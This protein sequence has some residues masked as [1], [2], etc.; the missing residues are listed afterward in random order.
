MTQASERYVLSA[1]GGLIDLDFVS[2]ALGGTYWAQERPRAVIEASLRNSLCFGAYEKEGGRQ[3]AFARIVTD[4]ATFSWLCDVVV[5]PAHRGHGLGKR[6]VAA[7]VA[8]PRVAGTFFLLATRDAH[9]LY[10]RFGFERIEMMKRQ[11]EPAAPPRSAS[12]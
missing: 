5:D 2:A 7:A 8:D 3:V 6:L 12:P 1:D 10:E 11:R 9:G 4:G